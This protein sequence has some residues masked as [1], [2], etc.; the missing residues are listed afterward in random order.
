ML[1]VGIRTYRVTAADFPI[2]IEVVAKKLPICQ[3]VA[4]RV[5]VTQNAA[6]TDSFPVT[7]TDDPGNKSIRYSIP[8]PTKGP[9]ADLVQNLD[10]VFPD[11]AP[12]DSRYEVTITSALN[13]RAKTTGSRPTLNPRT[14]TLTFQF[15]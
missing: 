11:D 5:Q 7:V 2:A 14:I 10:C 15:R 8:K 13:K 1:A 6:V 12:E 9:E 3:A 4:S